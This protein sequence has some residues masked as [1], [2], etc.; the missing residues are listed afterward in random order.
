MIRVTCNGWN[1]DKTAIYYSIE[2]LERTDLRTLK[3]ILDLHA[4]K[5]LDYMS[6]DDAKALSYKIGKCLKAAEEL[7]EADRAPVNDDE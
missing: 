7:E 3:F 5:W 2:N 1:Y 4:E 6:A